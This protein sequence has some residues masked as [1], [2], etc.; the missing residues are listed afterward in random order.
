MRIGIN[1]PGAIVH[2]SPEE[3]AE[4]VR[5]YG[6]SAASFPVDSRSEVHVIDAYKKAADD[7]DIVISEV[8]AWSS[9]FVPDPVQRQG[10]RGWIKRQLEL[11]DYI[12]ARCC[13]NVSGAFGE[14]WPMLYAENFG[15][16]AW[17]ENV[18]F[19]Q[20]LLDEVK[21]Q[22]T[23]FSLEPMQWMIPDSPE[24][25]L[26]FIHAV[27]RDRLKVHLDICNFVKDP[28]TYTHQ[29]ELIDRSFEL[30]GSQTVSCHLKDVL[31]D[32][33]V[34]TVAIREVPLGTGVFPVLHYLQKIDELDDVCVLLEHLPDIEAYQNALAYAKSIYTFTE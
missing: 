10:M 6:F 16:R 30:L 1:D 4:K 14:I 9:P 7:Y 31:L 23:V 8:G 34:I 21:P 13:V 29:D 19:M 17:E 15:P 3:W 27:N 22:H 2:T 20:D 33:G 11:A 5:N 28:Y 12:H 26:D 25:Y 32:P 18:R 24:Q